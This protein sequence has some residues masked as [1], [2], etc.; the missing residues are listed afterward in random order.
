M[1]KR[2]A[3]PDSM[4]SERVKILSN[5][6]DI[7]RKIGEMKQQQKNRADVEKKMAALKAKMKADY[8]AKIKKLL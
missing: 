6:G 4:K 5:R 7:D 3:L 2:L 8:E 1:K